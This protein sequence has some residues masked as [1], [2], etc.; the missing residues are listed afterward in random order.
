MRSALRTEDTRRA[1]R[2]WWPAVLAAVSVLAA[3]V[4]C[5]PVTYEQTYLHAG[6]NYAFRRAYPSVDALFNAFDFGHAALYERELRSPRSITRDVDTVLYAQVIG[7]V[8]RHPSRVTL[9]ETALAPRYT[10]MVPELVESFEW[11]HVLHRQLYDVLSD[12]RVSD[13]QRDARVA[14][15]MRYYRSRPDLALSGVPKSM[16]LMDGQAFSQTLRIAAPSYNALIWSYHWLQMVLYEALLA[17]PPGAARDTLVQRSVGTFWTLAQ[18]RGR[19]P[20][21]MPMSPA[22]APRFSSRYPEA[23]AIF[24]NLH[25]LHDVVGD[26]LASPRVAPSAKRAALLL[27]LRQYQDTVTSPLTRAE[28]TTMAR[29]MGVSAMGGT[30][31]P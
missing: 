11:A 12:A 21:V 19:T 7:D 24:D 28:W 3:Q 10:V 13:E 29:E 2:R 4:G 22:I 18:S 1:R 26:I 8:L 25:S 16:T 20:S 5:H 30:L 14:E 23:A 31:L 15:V 27:A 17:Q 6:H 9:D